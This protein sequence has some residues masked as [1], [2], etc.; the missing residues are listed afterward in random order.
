ML[1][2]LG[3]VRPSHLFDKRLWKQLGL[4]VAREGDAPDVVSAADLLRN[5]A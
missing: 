4:E 3:N 2:A 1:A 5:I